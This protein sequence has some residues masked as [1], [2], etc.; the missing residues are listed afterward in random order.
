[1]WHEKKKKKNSTED[2][3]KK[4]FDLKAVIAEYPLVFGG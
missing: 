3:N 1:M 4:K 2:L